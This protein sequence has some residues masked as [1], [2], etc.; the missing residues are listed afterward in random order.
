MRIAGVKAIYPHKKHNTSAKDQ[1]HKIYPYLL[2][3][4]ANT[5]RQI[6][7]NA[8]NHIWSGD[9]SY[10]RM[11]GGFMYLAAIIDW[12]SKCILAWKISNTMDSQLATDVL[13]LALDKHGTPEI[14]NSDQGSQYTSR[15]HTKILANNNISIS[16]NGKGRSIDN[17]AIERFFRSLKYENIYLHDY[18]SVSQLR[19]GVEQYMYFYNYNRFH[20]TLNYRKPMEVYLQKAA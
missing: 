15:A 16:M 6:V 9:I 10:I 7:A 2:K 19:H 3:Q 14:F 1:E 11:N 8:S 12:Y 18:S 5:D 13:E 4:F 17:I 20:S